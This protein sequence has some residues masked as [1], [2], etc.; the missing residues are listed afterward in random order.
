MC[1]FLAGYAVGSRDPETVQPVR[2]E[3]ISAPPPGPSKRPLEPPDC[4]DLYERVVTL[5]DQVAELT[6]RAADAE[7]ALAD[8][9]S[10]V[11]ASWGDSVPDVLS[12]KG[13]AKEVRKVIDE[14]GLDSELV[15]VD[16]AEPPCFAIFRD[17]EETLGTAL[18]VDCERWY[19]TFGPSTIEVFAPVDCGDGRTEQVMLLGSPTVWEYVDDPRPQDPKNRSKRF[20]VRAESI[21]SGWKCRE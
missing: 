2:G 9:V 13:F 11:P 14:C 6:K 17:A 8:E 19:R 5:E 18:Q 20:R 7:K 1:A 4:A 10:G 12:A 15:E 21:Y 3:V 16:C